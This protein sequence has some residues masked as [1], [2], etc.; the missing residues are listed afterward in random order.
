MLWVLARNRTSL[1]GTLPCHLMPRM[2][3]RHLKW[4]LLSLRSRDVQVVHACLAPVQQRTDDAGSIDTQ[5]GF[6]RQLGVLPD[7]FIQFSHCGSCLANSTVYFVLDGQCIGPQVGED[8]QSSNFSLSKL[9]VGGE[10]VSWAM[11]FVFFKLI[12]RPHSFQASEK[13][14]TSFC[15]PVSVCVLSVSHHPQRVA[16]ELGHCFDFGS[17]AGSVEKSSISSGV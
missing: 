11:I 13:L 3:R 12:C 1:F 10:R 17:E 9:M 16:N 14:D 15:K 7:P 6:L 2:R 4:K 5:F 8:V